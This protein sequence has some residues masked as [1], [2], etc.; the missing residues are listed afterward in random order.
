[1]LTN[2]FTDFLHFC[3]LLAFIFDYVRMVVFLVYRI[4]AGF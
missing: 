4:F 2:I 1:M 3:T